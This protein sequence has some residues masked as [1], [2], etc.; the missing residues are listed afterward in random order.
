[1]EVYTSC[2]PVAKVK[3]SNTK[4]RAEITCEHHFFPVYSHCHIPNQLRKRWSIGNFKMS[5]SASADSKR[6]F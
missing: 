3:G 5:L 4:L 6:D 2:S 1:M